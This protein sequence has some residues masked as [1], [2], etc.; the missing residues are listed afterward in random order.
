MEARPDSAAVRCPYPGLRPFR[1]DE[2]DLFFGREAQ[3]E[4]ML[5][6]L[7]SHHFL[8]VVGVSGC[9]KSSLV[10][11]GLLPALEAGFLSD[12][13][14]DWRMAIM[15]PGEAPFKRLAEALSQ[16]AALGPERGS[17]P[18]ATAFLEAALRRGH[19]GLVE[20]VAETHLPEGTHLIL[21]VD[22][23]EEIFRYR[24]QAEN[25][26]DADAF[27]NLLLASAAVADTQ[28]TPIYV[29]ITMRSDFI[30]DCAVF[31]GLPEQ[32]SESQFLTPRL[33]RSQYRAAIEEPARLFGGELAPELVNQLLN[34][35]STDPDQLPVLQHA[36]MRMW[37]R[38]GGGTGCRLTLADY[39]AVG[40]LASALSQHADEALQELDPA[41]Q[42]IAKRLFQCLCE[43][44]AKGRDT[45][46][47][48]WLS[49]V[50]AVAGVEVEAVKPVVEV[51]RRSDRC[52]LTPPAPVALT[53]DTVLDISHESLI[54]QW[55]QLNDWVQETYI[56]MATGLRTRRWLEIA[57]A[58]IQKRLQL[59]GRCLCLV[60]VDVDHFKRVNDQYGH[61][62]GDKMLYAVAHSLVNLI[63]SNDIIVRFGEDEFIILLPGV[64][65]PEAETI[66]EQLRAGIA[67]LKIPIDSVL[68]PLSITVSLG[69][70]RMLPNETLGT[71]VAR[72]DAALYRAK[73]GGRNRVAGPRREAAI[74]WPGT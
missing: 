50:A 22:Q 30:G 33:T 31:T 34:D 10:Q 26:N 63:R 15:R 13:G 16:E 57:Y 53:A 59:D 8:A 56:D 4:A 58:R 74:A 23:F 29:V 37:L 70:A 68:E 72:A 20:A 55:R 38:A 67:A 36:L 43:R 49:E 18:T 66:A 73:A 1:R 46:R 51:F 40:G 3:I 62:V 6:K 14:P 64:D 60:M 27:V 12:A 11:A 48:V 45:R 5:A 25:S 47:P 17:D 32:I 69:V 71:L 39:E 35:I 65:L 24:R 19:L 52:F 2:T 41:Q 21:V 44:G 54:R 7:E 28:S 42:A 61:P 9:G